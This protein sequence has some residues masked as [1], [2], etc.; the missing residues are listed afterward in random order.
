MTYTPALLDHLRHLEA[1]YL[2]DV[3]RA[4][5]A[6][7]QACLET[8][9]LGSP[10]DGGALLGRSSYHSVAGEPRQGIETGRVGQNPA[11]SGDPERQCTGGS[12]R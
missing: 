1:R 8:P 2:E 6:F 10:G 7:L 5:A 3:H 12:S 11:P 4:K 9:S